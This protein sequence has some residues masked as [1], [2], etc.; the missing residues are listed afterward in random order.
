VLRRR[1]GIDHAV[2]CYGKDIILRKS[3]DERTEDGY[4]YGAPIFLIGPG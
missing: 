4:A 2:P 3:I 1:Y